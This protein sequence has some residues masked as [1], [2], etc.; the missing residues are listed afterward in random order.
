M[1]H[2]RDIPNSPYK[3]TLSSYP[4]L[5][6][7]ELKTQML[8]PRSL[9][10]E[11]KVGQEAGHL[12]RGRAV[13]VLQNTSSMAILHPSSSTS[14]ADTVPT[15]SILR[16]NAPFLVERA[17]HYGDG[18]KVWRCSSGLNFLCSLWSKLNC[19]VRFSVFFVLFSKPSF[20]YALG[21]R[22]Y[23]DSSIDSSSKW[24]PR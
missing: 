24:F 2:A 6:P 7:A 22:P 12:K 14:P 20:L 15:I 11:V 21:S 5:A 17:L 18:S 3:F 19:F 8:R 4:T 16:I 1:R 10:R 13:N 23:S 9:G